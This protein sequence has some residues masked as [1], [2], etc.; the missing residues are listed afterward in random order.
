MPTASQGRSVARAVTVLNVVSAQSAAPAAM[1]TVVPAIQPTAHQRMVARKH[2]T[3][4][5]TETTVVSAMT[6]V[7]VGPTAPRA[8]LKMPTTN[9]PLPR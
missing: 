1:L 6:V 3:T 2:A 8:V 9:K 7:T 5:A 4:V